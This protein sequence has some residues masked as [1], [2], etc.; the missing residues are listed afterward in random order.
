[1][2]NIWILI[3][4]RLLYNELDWDYEIQN[5]ILRNINPTSEL[6]IELIGN[7]QSIIN[8]IL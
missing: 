8:Q 4:D 1:V 3:I 2:V 6:N 7:R 5:L